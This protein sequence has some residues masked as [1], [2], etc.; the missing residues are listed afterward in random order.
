MKN[1]LMLKPK[2][3]MAIH[4]WLVEA[5][6][7]RAEGGGAAPKLC[8]TKACEI[9]I[10]SEDKAAGRFAAWMHAPFIP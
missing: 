2:A 10:R 3:T 7:V 8:S 9:G 4:S 1:E 6:E 5:S